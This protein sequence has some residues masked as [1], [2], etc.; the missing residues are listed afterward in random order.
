M[1]L[2]GQTTLAAPGRADT[3]RREHGELVAA[4]EL[5]DADAAER[6]A[7]SH[8]RAALRVRLTMTMTDSNGDMA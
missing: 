7:R 8:I 2:L 6:S 4:L 3:S 5:R 1:L